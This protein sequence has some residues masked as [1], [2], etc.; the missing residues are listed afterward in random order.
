[1]K[2][3]NLYNYSVLMSVYFK[4]NPEYLK[5]SIESMLSQTMPT[6]DFV[7][8]KDGVLGEELNNVISYYCRLHND[9]FN[10]IEVKENVGLGRA[11]NIGLK[12]CKNE[13]VARMDSDDF[14]VPERCEIQMNYLKQHVEIDV[15][16]TDTFEFEDYYLWIRVLKNGGIIESLGNPLVYMRAGLSMYSR[17]GGMKY[18]KNI[19]NFRMK[20]YRQ[21]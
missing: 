7:L 21:K 3:D 16:G 5:L 10:I 19:I 2:K 14:S 11:L 8:V 13:Y 17:R 9:I 1:M 20:S 15:L 12:H 18:V 4:E 6:N